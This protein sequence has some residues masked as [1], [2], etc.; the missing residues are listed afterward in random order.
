MA[1]LA[2][3]YAPGPASDP[4]VGRPLGGGLIGKLD[5]TVITGTYRTG[6]Y[7]A[8]IVFHGPGTAPDGLW[9]YDGI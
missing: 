4:I 9:I 6:S 7:G 8:S 1:G 5:S 2:I 3:L